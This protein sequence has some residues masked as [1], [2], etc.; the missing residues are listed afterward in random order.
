MHMESGTMSKQELVY[1]LAVF[2]IHANNI[3]VKIERRKR[4]YIL[5]CRVSFPDISLLPNKDI[6]TQAI[7]REL[8]TR[9]KKPMTVKIYKKGFYGYVS[10]NYKD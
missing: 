4:A 7:W 8:E 3:N 1:F 5:V 10:I 6:I 2:S 9:G